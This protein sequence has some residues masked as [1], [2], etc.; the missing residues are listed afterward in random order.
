[1][2]GGDLLAEGDGV[3]G[4][5][6]LPV[7]GSEVGPGGQGAGVAGAEDPVAVAGGL[8]PV[9]GSGGVQ[10]RAEQA[11]SREEQYWVPVRLPQG[12]TSMAG[13]NPG[14][15]AERGSCLRHGLIGVRPR[16]G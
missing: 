5:P 1:M 6:G 8:L 13:Q 7:G 10:A 3:G 4:A 11:V 9:A 2:P 15:G 14:I 16:F 12:I